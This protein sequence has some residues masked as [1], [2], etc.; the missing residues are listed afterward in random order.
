V[1]APRPELVGEE[2][3]KE[4]PMCVCG[5]RHQRN[6]DCSI[7]DCCCWFFSPRQVS[8][9]QK[10]VYLGIALVVGCPIVGLVIGLVFWGWPR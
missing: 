5:H 6:E 7:V 10:L 1:T 9:D 8:S 2:V 4:V 3:R